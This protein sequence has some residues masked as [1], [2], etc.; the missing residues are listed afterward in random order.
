[1][2]DLCARGKQALAR[3]YGD[4]VRRYDAEGAQHTRLREYSNGSGLEHAEL[5]LSIELHLGRQLPSRL[6][7]DACEAKSV[8]VAELSA[9][10]KPELA[11][12][13]GQLLALACCGQD[14]MWRMAARM[15]AQAAEGGDDALLKRG[16]RHPLASAF[17]DGYD[18]LED[19]RSQMAHMEKRPSCAADRR[20]ADDARGAA[21]QRL[22]REL[23]GVRVERH[24]GLRAASTLSPMLQVAVSDRDS[25]L[26]AKL[27]KRLL[28]RKR[29]VS[30]LQELKTV[31]EGLGEHEA[32]EP[33]GAA[34]EVEEPGEL[35]PDLAQAMDQL[36]LGCQRTGWRARVTL[37][38]PGEV[39]ERAVVVTV[40]AVE[41]A[42]NESEGEVR[43]ASE[44]EEAAIAP[45]TSE[46]SGGRSDGFRASPGGPAAR[47][48][49]ELRGGSRH[50]PRVPATV[51]GETKLP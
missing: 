13:L 41:V 26:L 48:T 44:P 1:L 37:F 45:S 15:L 20:R 18:E 42:T 11:L 34:P 39:E 29:P 9:E 50:R 4:D 49:D 24:M 43:P 17:L 47:A 12:R 19:W 14:A 27:G 31:L 5:R 40:G 2:R 7:E 35:P 8:A 10:A 46:L 25:A 51:P 16:S 23:R 33:E 38:P 6:I 30:G 32:P 21:R 3:A 36:R 22:E 28:K